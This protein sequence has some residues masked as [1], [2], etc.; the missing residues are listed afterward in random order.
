MDLLDDIAA[1]PTPSRL[2]ARTPTPERTEHRFVV[3]DREGLVDRYLPGEPARG[4]LVLVP[5]FTPDGKDDPQLVD[6]ATSFARARFLVV[7]PEMPGARDLRVGPEDID[8]IADAGAFTLDEDLCPAVAFAAISYAVG[9][10]VIA[11]LRPEIAPRLDHLTSLGGYHDLLAVV[12][13]ATTGHYRRSSE[14]RWR[15]R[16]PQPF[17]RW[18]FLASNLDLVADEDDRERLRAMADRRLA[19]PRAPI[20]DLAAGLGPEGSA[21]HALLDNT[22][23]DRVPSLIE[24]LPAA[25]QERMEALSLAGRDLSPLEGRLILI[26]GR[27]DDMIPPTESEALARAVSDVELFLIPG[28][29]HIDPG[30]VGFLGQWALVRAVRAMLA[31]QRPDTS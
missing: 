9:P 7:V 16:E 20:E 12:T 28:F 1:G 25:M 13:F 18:V 6:L 26:H 15:H 5:G 17:G 24:A 23:P 4:C 19:D 27:E 14:R 31:R 22:D 2:K 8:A 3:L 30:R 11:A 29:T 10:T 21:V